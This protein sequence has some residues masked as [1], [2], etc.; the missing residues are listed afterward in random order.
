MMLTCGFLQ[1]GGVGSLDIAGLL[2]NPH[3]ITMVGTQLQ[4]TCSGG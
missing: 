2:N 3:F 4:P 1:T